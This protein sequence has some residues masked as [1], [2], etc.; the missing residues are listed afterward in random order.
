MEETTYEK[1]DET[2]IKVV[3]PVEVQSEEKTYDLDFLRQQEIDI[4]KQKN[5]FVEAR[6]KELAEV[7]DL[8]AK[9]EELGVKSNLEIEQAKELTLEK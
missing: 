1:V 9:C 7:R 5:D 2:T 6:N 4:L 3:K 8:I